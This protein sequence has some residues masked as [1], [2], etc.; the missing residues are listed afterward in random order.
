MRKLIGSVLVLAALALTSAEC[1]AQR[2][3]AARRAPPPA[4]A[5]RTSFGAELAYGTES[6]IGLGARVVFRLRS[7]FPRTPIDGQVGFQYFFPSEPAGVNLS[8]W[9]LNGNLAYRIPNVRG[10]LA[11]YVGGGLNIAH[12]SVSP[13]GSNTEA[14]LNLLAGTTFRVRGT[15]MPFAEARVRAGGGAD[16]LVIAGGA[17]F[18][19]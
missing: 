14:G 5:Q 8:Y 15:A 2:R 17:R 13:G 11:P 4:P 18:R 16:Q 10:T 3:P 7:L 19:L 1:M 6:D 12:A 9:E